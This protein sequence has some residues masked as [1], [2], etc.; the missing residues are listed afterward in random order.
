MV[1]QK[2]LDAHDKLYFLEFDHI[3]HTVPETFNEPVSNESGNLLMENFH[4]PGIDNKCRNENESLN[5]MYR[6]FILSKASGAALWWFDMF[7]G[8]FRSDAMMHAVTHMLEIERQLSDSD[9]HSIAEIAVFAEGESMYRVRK[10]SPIA[11]GCLGTILRTMAECGAPFDLY[12][13]SDIMLPQI[14]RYSFYIF[15]N[16]Y[17]IPDARKEQIRSICAQSGKTVLW[18]YAPDYAHNGENKPENIA[19]VAGIP[20]MASDV[21]HGAFIYEDTPYSGCTC[22][23]FFSIP[24]SGAKPLAYW[25]DGTIAAAETMLSGCRSIY[26]A[27]YHLPSTFLRQLLK[28]SGVFLYSENPQ[29]FTYANSAFLGVY[30]AGDFTA[31]I[32][33]R[34][35]GGYRDLISGAYFRADDGMLRLP[36]RTLR[37]YLLASES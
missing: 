12:T 13:I 1:T 10:S 5:L 18:L 28:E 19:A 15:I 7:D 16:E 30:H 2:T 26:A 35:D 20:V 9:K 24:A 22:A 33:V 25:E 31:E 34:K 3:T 23:P 32:H 14:S 37:A 11:S 36:P 29:V 8:W 17:D 4:I 27:A 21:P 6:E